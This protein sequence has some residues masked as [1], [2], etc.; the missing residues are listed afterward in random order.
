MT[1]ERKTLLTTHRFR[2]EEVQQA[3]PGG[4]TRPRQVVRHPGAVAVVPMI[5]DDHVCLIRNYRVAVDTVLIEIPAGTLEPNEPPELTA[6]RELIEE[7]GYVAGSLEKLHDFLL[8]PGITDERMYVYIARDLKLGP[9]AREEG[10]DIE[11]LIVS[12]SEAMAM[13]ERGEIQDAKTLVG[14]LWCDRRR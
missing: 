12:W 6:G 8:S 3:V 11:N 5:D 1:T 10:E 7:T 9:T 4:G 13:V 14:L 2:V